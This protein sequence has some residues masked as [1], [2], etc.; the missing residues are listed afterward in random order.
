VLP[1]SVVLDGEYGHAD[2]GF[3]VPVRLGAG[4]VERVLEWEL[5]ATE[6]EQ[7]DAAAAKLAEQYRTITA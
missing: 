1:A 4:G 5:D 2:T 3:G 7:L 6:R